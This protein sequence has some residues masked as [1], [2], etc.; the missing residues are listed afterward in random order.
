LRNSITIAPG[1]LVGAGAIIM[2]DTVEEGVY[3]PES[4]KL[5][6]KNSS[7]IDL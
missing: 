3:L 1:T 2:K 6:S 7:E 5:F 4:A